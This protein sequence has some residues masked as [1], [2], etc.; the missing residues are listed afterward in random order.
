MNTFNEKVT[1]LSANLARNPVSDDIILKKNEEA[2]KQ[3]VN[4]LLLSDQFACIGRPFVCAGLKRFIN[5]PG[6][7]GKIAEI[8]NRVREAMRYETRVAVDALE[9]TYVDSAKYVSIVMT[10]RFV[11]AERVF[12]YES[13]LRRIL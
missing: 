8:K 2:I 9:V 11:N 6:T 13:R 10:L 3:H 5:E 7:D 4:F 12:K 1:D